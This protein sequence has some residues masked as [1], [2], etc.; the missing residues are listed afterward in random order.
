[1]A[2]IVLVAL[3]LAWD[4]MW[5]QRSEAVGDGN[6]TLVEDILVGEAALRSGMYIPPKLRPKPTH[7]CTL[8]GRIGGK[9]YEWQLMVIRPGDDLGYEFCNA[10]AHRYLIKV[11]E[12]NL[13]QITEIKGDTK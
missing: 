8:H 12:E 3:A 11:L 7:N 6:N 2:L 13:P 5:V 9:G 1:M 10:C 4:G